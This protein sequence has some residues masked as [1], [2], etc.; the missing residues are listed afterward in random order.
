MLLRR[1]TRVRVSVIASLVAG[2][3]LA[4]HSGYRPDVT[5]AAGRAQGS[6]ACGVVVNHGAAPAW[7]RFGAPGG[8]PYLLADGGRFA[9][10]LFSPTL[11]AGH[12]TQPHN[13]ILWVVGGPG[14]SR[15]LQVTARRIGSS[16]V[17]HRRYHSVD[18]AG[19]IYPTYLDLPSSGCWTLSVVRSARAAH[20]AVRIENQVR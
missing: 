6:G 19:R 20:V 3:I 1:A 18:R 7:A 13:K 5:S 9:G 17:E 11:R 2:A 10:F 12:A 14:G 4:G 16:Q 15:T 8:T